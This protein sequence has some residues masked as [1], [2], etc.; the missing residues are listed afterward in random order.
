[1]QD[2]TILHA[3]QPHSCILSESH[4]AA[5]QVDSMEVRDTGPG[6]ASILQEMGVN[7]DPHRLAKAL[8]GRQLEINTRALRI[9]YTLG[10]FIAGL[11]KVSCYMCDAQ[12]WAFLF[13]Y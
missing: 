11:A 10:R 13:L 4:H 8:K 6:L 1:M 9:T 5:L 2:A 12:Y 3:T 7:Y